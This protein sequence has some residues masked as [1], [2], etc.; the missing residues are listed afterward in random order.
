VI[1]YLQTLG[2]TPTVTLQTS[3]HYYTAAGRTGCRRRLRPPLPRREPRRVRLRPR[4]VRPPAPRRAPATAR[5][6]PPAAP[7]ERRLRRP[8]ERDT[9]N[10]LVVLIVATVFVLLRFRRANLLTWAA[11]GGWGYTS[12]FDSDSLPRFPARSSRSTWEIASIAILAYSSSQPAAPRRN[13]RPPRRFM[14]EKRYTSA[15][16]RDG[17]RH[18]GARG[19]ERLRPDERPHPASSLSRER[20]I[21]HP[22]RRSR[23]TTRG[24]I[25][26]AGENPFWPLEKSNPEGVSQ[27]RRERTP[28]LTIGT[29]S[30]AMAITCRHRH[31]RA[32]PGPD[33][34]QPPRNDPL[35]RDTYLFWRH[36]QGGPG[37]PK[38]EGP[39]I[40]PCR[41][42]RSS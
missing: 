3:H 13:L 14:T 8:R 28:G 38:K 4:R 35:L 7:P 29:A 21:L 22:R 39:G 10:I 31:V 27:T 18:P 40:Q 9:M 41:P 19:R 23:F 32:R 12:F 16:W 17:R 37:L 6:T 36:F 11:H 2:G 1:A 33:P 15:A 34:D 20:S 25:S 26:T 5:G 30:S 24:S 42:G